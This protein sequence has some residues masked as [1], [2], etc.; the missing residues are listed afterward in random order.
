MAAKQ[1]V[2]ILIAAI[3]LVSHSGCVSGVIKETTWPA[4]TLDTGWIPFKVYNKQHYKFQYEDVTI[5]VYFFFFPFKNDLTWVGPPLLPVIPL[6]SSSAGAGSQPKS[7]SLHLKI[8]NPARQTSLD[9]S[10]S[11]IEVSEQKT[12]RVAEANAA[13]KYI[14]G[15]PDI[16]MKYQEIPIGKVSMPQGK[17]DYFLTFQPFDSE[18]QTF[19]IDLGFI[20]VDDK[21]VPLPTL[22]VHKDFKNIYRP[23]A[24]PEHGF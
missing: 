4:D 12:L 13:D 17:M 3:G 2:A 14:E 16:V 15:Y 23:L 20:Q 9:F 18:P 11:R 21:K 1:L 24:I 7:L 22:R 6:P 5:D 8:T 19:L 10:E